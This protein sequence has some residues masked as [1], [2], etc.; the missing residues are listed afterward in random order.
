MTNSGRIT[1]S[2][3]KTIVALLVPLLELSLGSLTTKIPSDLGKVSVTVLIFLVGMLTLLYLY[4]HVLKADWPAFRAHIWRNLGIAVLLT[5]GLSG[6]LA[7]V[8]LG[9]QPFMPASI[10]LSAQSTA[11]LGLIGS[12]TALMAPFSEEIVFRYVLFYQWRNRGLLTPVMFLVS[13]A[14]FGL[15]HWNNF[16]GNVMQMIPY[17]VIGAVFS[18]IYWVSQNIWQNIATHFLFDFVQ[19]LAA[20]VMFILTFATA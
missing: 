20:I 7:L 3:V 1:I 17:M 19:V 12:V 8:R 2:P 6:V 16:S 4:G 15:V 13:A 14:A 9:L 18:I 10:M 5:V 11:T